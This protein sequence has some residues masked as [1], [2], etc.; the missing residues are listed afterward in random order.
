MGMKAMT[1]NMQRCDDRN[2]VQ[3]SSNLSGDDYWCA[4]GCEFSMSSG[5]SECWISDPFAHDEI[6]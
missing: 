3:A 2:D 1:V 4:S 6:I 5:V